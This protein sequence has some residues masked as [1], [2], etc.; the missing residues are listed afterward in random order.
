MSAKI[1]F[2]TRV[3]VNR[4]NEKARNRFPLQ[5]DGG[6]VILHER[7]LSPDRRHPGLKTQEIK[8]S[9]EEFAALFEAYNQ[10]G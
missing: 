2:Q 5:V 3:E 6:E 8:V 10:Q 7:R 4:R 1:R 9:S